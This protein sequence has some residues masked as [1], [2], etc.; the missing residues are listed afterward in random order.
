MSGEN[1][2]DLWVTVFGF[3]PVTA[4]QVLND[5]GSTSSVSEYRLCNESNWLHI[6]FAT[7]LEVA[8]ALRKNGKLFGRNTMIGVLPCT[9]SSVLLSE[10][11][12]ALK[13]VPLRERE[14][15]TSLSVD[16]PLR[17]INIANE[18]DDRFSGDRNLHTPTR[19]LR[20]LNKSTVQV[21]TN[22]QNP[23][24]PVGSPFSKAVEYFIGR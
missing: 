9:D 22:A 21:Q 10:E 15:V 16:S 17:V 19:G 4:K 24:R 11:E 12:A 14:N 20:Q 18:N 7:R 23:E 1:E 2:L 13:S 6:K 5:F 3:N 8:K